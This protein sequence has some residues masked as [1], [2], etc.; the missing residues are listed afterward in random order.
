MLLEAILGAIFLPIGLAIVA[1]VY[2][3]KPSLWDRFAPK[4]CG[5]VAAA[6]GVYIAFCFL[7]WFIIR[8]GD[9]F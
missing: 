6:V 8:I 5:M 7:I 9:L 4:G 3:A 2:N 1:A